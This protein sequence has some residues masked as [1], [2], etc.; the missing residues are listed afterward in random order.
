M[1]NFIWQQPQVV[2]QSQCLLDSYA[3]Y[4]GKQLIT[5]IGDTLLEA[6]T[7]FYVPFVVVAHNTAPD[8]ILTYGNQ[9]ALQLWEMNW[10]EFCQTPSRCTA[11][12]I[13]R[14]ERQRM[15]TL[16]AQ[17]GFIDNYQGIRISRSGKRFL[18]NKAI[19]WNLVNSQGE[20]CGQAATFSN[21]EYCD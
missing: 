1:T 21:W 8:P 3:K 16:A 10:D 17:Q 7:L 5:R 14:E 12:P 2:N 9:I 13:N 15:L 19:I 6:E 4:L 18:I 20:A 11:E